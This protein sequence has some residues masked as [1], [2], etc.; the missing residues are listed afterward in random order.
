MLEININIYLSVELVSDTGDT[1]R[2]VHNF[3]A[4]MNNLFRLRLHQL[5]CVFVFHRFL[6]DLTFMDFYNDC[7]IIIGHG[8]DTASV[9]C[10]ITLATLDD[11]KHFQRNVNMSILMSVI[12]IIDCSTWWAQCIECLCMFWDLHGIRGLVEEWQVDS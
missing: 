8:H 10:W 12:Y 1:F 9:C 7:V 3:V 4:R 6:S 5:A 2:R 11:H